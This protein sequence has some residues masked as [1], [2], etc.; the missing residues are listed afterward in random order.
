MKRKPFPIGR[1]FLYPNDT[2]RAMNQKS[3]IIIGAGMAGLSA[4]Y[5][6]H[7]AGWGVTVLEA[8]GRVGGRV[9]SIR[10]FSNGLVAE[11]GGEFIDE[12]HTRM[13]GLA[14]EFNLSLGKVGSW[15]GQSEDW[16]AFENKAGPLVD[17][18]LWGANLNVEYEKMWTSLAELGKLVPDPANPLTTPNAK[19]L[20]SKNAAEWIQAQD[21]H[22]L[23]CVLFSNQIRSEFTCE[24]VDFS[25]LDL[26]R[27]A[28]MY[29]SNPEKWDNT[30]RVVGGNDLI[31]HAIASRLPDVRLN[32]VVMSMRVQVEEVVVKYK[33]VDS[34][35]TLR[36]SY[37][38]LATPL[39]T[40]RMMDFGGTLPA[41]HQNMLTGLSYGSVTKVLIEYRKR[42]WHDRNWNGRL[43]TDLPIVLTWDA[44]SHLDR[45]HGIL[46]AYTGGGPGA[47]LS[48]LSDDERTKTAVSVIES[49]FPG[50]SDLIE[51]TQTVAWV[52]EP[53]T[54]CSYMAYAP[55]ELTSHWQTLFSPAGRLYFAGEH[56]TVIQ[57]YME[58]AVE[59]GQRAAKEIIGRG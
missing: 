57:G 50:S 4:A 22:P 16:G 11:G 17:E 46:T 14:R 21:V 3:V 19:E 34:F 24:P 49:I 43:N 53:F 44:T 5:E 27:N 51:G 30:Y 42:F 8:R 15:Q 1:R 32:A 38:I 13:L 31:P 28:A 18:N 20:D 37:A 12:H 25:L 52:N 33:H 54:R 45:E 2:I 26:A 41:S 10:E 35:H 23:A 59:S 47:E 58:G 36:A 6:L 55:N 48:A 29:Y 39:T 9:Y 40:A 56:A 7:K